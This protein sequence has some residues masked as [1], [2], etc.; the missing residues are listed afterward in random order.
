MGV[1]IFRPTSFREAQRRISPLG[2]SSSHKIAS[3]TPSHTVEPTNA[4]QVKMRSTRLFAACITLLSLAV[5]CT[6]RKAPAKVFLIAGDDNVEGFARLQQLEDR[7]NDEKFAA[8]DEALKY[9]HLRDTKT[10]TW[11][12]RKDVFVAYERERHKPLQGPLNMHDYGGLPDESFGPEVEMGHVLGNA[13]DEPVIL[14]KAGWREKSLGHDFLPPSSNGLTGFQWIRAVD[15]VKDAIKNAD[16]IIG[17]RSYRNG[18]AELAGVVW[19]HGYSDMVHTDYRKSYQINLEHLLQDLRHTFGQPHLPIVVGEL[20]GSGNNP[21]EW[22]LEIRGYQKE[23]C[24]LK[25]FNRTTAFVETAKYV[26]RDS[27]KLDNNVHYYGRGDTMIEIGNSFAVELL[28]LMNSKEEFGEADTEMEVELE[29]DDENEEFS[30]AMLMIFVVG[31]AALGAAAYQ[32][33][34]SGDKESFSKLTRDNIWRVVRFFRPED[35]IRMKE[36]E[37]EDEHVEFDSLPASDSPLY[38]LD[39]ISSTEGD[40][41]HIHEFA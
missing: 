41:D 29:M 19:W 7:L 6:S 24:S 5:P 1:I 11:A 22:E 36:K 32:R 34:R 3:T 37:E 40:G 20:G 28:N 25:K 23:V 15:A 27:H 26:H 33:Y 18:R 14:V 12:T 8:S 17:S 10:K 16:K 31:L 39:E 30:A 13:F 21:S 4:T 2:A 38:E 35:D 9:A